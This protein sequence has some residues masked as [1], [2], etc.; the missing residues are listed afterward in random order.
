MRR[1]TP[2]I[3]TALL[4]ALLLASLTA[5][6]WRQSR[7]LEILR[8]LDDT[9][10]ERVVEEARRSALLRRVEQL[11]S[12]A[13]VSEAA[14][15]RFGMRLPEGDEIVILPLRHPPSGLAGGD[16]SG[17]DEAEGGSG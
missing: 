14:R 17:T 16:R 10:R 11:E 5:V 12:R 2:V 1:G 6:V 15:D 8:H 7:A 3:R 9:R 13:R 4:L